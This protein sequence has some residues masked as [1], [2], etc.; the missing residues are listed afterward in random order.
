MCCTTIF[1][2]TFLGDQPLFRLCE[3]AIDLRDFVLA[4][5]KAIIEI[6]HLCQLSQVYR[7][8]SLLAT[9]EFH[10]LWDHIF[11][12]DQQERSGCQAW[13]ALLWLT[14]FPQV[15]EAG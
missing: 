3:K 9:L 15:L 12:L 4:Y 5:L 2:K 11:Y 13:V 10:C 6:S 1:L 8:P 14:K 7:D